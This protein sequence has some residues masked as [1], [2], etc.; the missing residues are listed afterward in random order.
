MKSPVLILM[1]LA[2]SGCVAQQKPA[3]TP[4][5]PTTMDWAGFAE[6]TE[7]GVWLGGQ[8]SEEA[9]DEFAA[10]G[11]RLVVNLRT[12]DEMAFFPYCERALA[13]RGMTYI[14]IPTR[15]SEL[16]AAEYEALE[17]AVAGHD[18]PVMLH[19]ASGGRAT[20]LWAMKRMR[21]EGV[22]AEQA[23]VWCNERREKPWEKGAEILRAF[24]AGD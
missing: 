10:R 1:M 19:C 18:G 23:I 7:P 14:R 9:I 20:Y 15:G 17:H 13:G 12:D 22:S 2:L 3:E 4:K 24:E 11:G 5:P 6:A 21:D 16:D 8:P